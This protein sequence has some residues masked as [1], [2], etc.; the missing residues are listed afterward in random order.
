MRIYIRILLAALL[1]I[2]YY[3]VICIIAGTDF[4]DPWKRLMRWAR[5]EDLH[6]EDV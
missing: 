5:K 1:F 2:L 4:G 3:A 6:N